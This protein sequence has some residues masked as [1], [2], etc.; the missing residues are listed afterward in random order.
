MRTNVPS[1]WARSSRARRGKGLEKA[2]VGRPAD[3]GEVPPEEAL[4]DVIEHCGV[5]S[6]AAMR[7][8]LPHHAGVLVGR[9][10]ADPR[11]LG[12]RPELE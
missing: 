8:C 4:A 2:D 1:S 3:A 6:D 11:D 9:R 12:R 7:E 10:L 5:A